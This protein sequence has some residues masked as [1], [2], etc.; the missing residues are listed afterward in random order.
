MAELMV[1]LMNDGRSV[2]EFFL[3]DEFSEG[4]G[5]AATD[6]SY[7]MSNDD[8][9]SSIPEQP[10]SWKDVDPDAVDAF[11]EAV[12]PWWVHIGD[13]FFK[14]I[15]AAKEFRMR[16]VWMRELIGGAKA[17]G[18][19]VDEGASSG[20]TTKKRSVEDLVN[21]IAKNNGA[22][23]MAIGDSD[24]LTS[25]LHEEFSD[26]I[27]DRFAD[28][29]D[30]LV[31]WNEEGKRNEGDDESE[32]VTYPNT[33]P[34]LSEAFA[35]TTPSASVAPSPRSNESE[36]VSTKF[37]FACGEKIPAVAKFCPSCGKRQ[38]LS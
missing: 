30:L 5:V 4:G 14:D 36:S 26:A 29:S 20:T 19:A 27:L 10:R 28:L 7:L 16:S 18:G 22:L 1:Q 38:S 35:V 6:A 12:G 17:F 24:F 13:D 37:C 25:A 32:A 9:G 21:D 31:Q 2:E 11:S 34:I 3:G 15:V 23:T 8:D 33:E